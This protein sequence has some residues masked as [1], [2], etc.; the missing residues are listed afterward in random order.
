VGKKKGEEVVMKRIAFVAIAL[1]LA[2]S[3]GIGRSSARPAAQGADLLRLLPDGTGVIVVDVQK[4]TSSSL[5]ATISDKGPVKDVLQKMQQVSELG[6]SINDYKTVAVVFGPSGPNN[7]TAAV[8]GTFNQTDLLA[9]ARADQRIKVTSEKYKNYEIY[10]VARAAQTERKKEDLAFMFPEAGTVVAGT[11][12]GVRASIDTLTGAKAGIGQNVKLSSA[13][14]SDP[15]AAVRFAI[16][17]TPAMTSGLQS[18]EVPLPDFSSINL[19]FGGVDFTS[20]VGINATLRSNTAE[21]A[22]GLADRLNGI[23]GMA[24]AYMG[25]SSDPKMVALNDALKTVTIS[26]AD[27]DVKITGNLPM[28]LLSQVLR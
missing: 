7:F 21:Q 28:E 6:V 8:S 2:I 17:M 23:L 13:I 18:T 16:E 24:K 15:A 11:Q 27:A 20:G 4:V 22:K 14:N 25:S 3:T 19:V 12:A 10:N 5:W 9:R 1:A 26:G